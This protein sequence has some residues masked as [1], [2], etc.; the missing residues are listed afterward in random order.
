[1][2]IKQNDKRVVFIRKDKTL[3]NNKWKVVKEQSKTGF[4]YI[5]DTQGVSIMPYRFDKSGKMEVLIREEPNPLHQTILTVIAGKR[6]DHEEGNTW[7]QETAQRELGEESGYWVDDKHSFF[8]LGDVVVGKDYKEKDVFVAVD[9]TGVTP[10]KMKPDKGSLIEKNAKNHWVPVELLKR[11]LL[12]QAGNVD[13]YFMAMTSKFLAHMGLMKSEE[14]DLLK[15][16]AKIT[17]AKRVNVRPSGPSKLKGK[18]RPGHKYIRREPL[19]GGGYNYIYEEP[20]GR[21]KKA[22]EEPAKRL[23]DQLA[24]LFG[25]PQGQPE[26]KAPKKI[27]ILKEYSEIP[28]SLGSFTSE[29]SA[30]EWMG[31]IVD[32]ATKLSYSFTSSAAPVNSLY[33]FYVDSGRYL[34][35]GAAEIKVENKKLQPAAQAAVRNAIFNASRMLAAVHGIKMVLNSSKIE[36]LFDLVSQKLDDSDSKE[37]LATYEESQSFERIML[38]ALDGMKSMAFDINDISW[39]KGQDPKLDFVRDR[40][41]EAVD[42]LMRVRDHFIMSTFKFFIDK[43]DKKLDNLNDAFNIQAAIALIN[44][45]ETFTNSVTRRTYNRSDMRDFT[46]QLNMRQKGVYDGSA[47][48]LANAKKVVVDKIRRIVDAEGLASNFLRDKIVNS[49]SFSFLTLSS[50]GGSY[51]EDLAENTLAYIE[52]FGLDRYKQDFLFMSGLAKTAPIEGYVKYVPTAPDTPKHPLYDAAFEIMEKVFNGEDIYSDASVEDIY[53]RIFNRSYD[54]IGSLQASPMY[55][56]DIGGLGAV[57]NT[58]LLLNEKASPSSKSLAFIK[59]WSKFSGA[60]I[61]ANAIEEMV[62][63][64]NIDRGSYVNYHLA[65]NRSIVVKNEEMKKALGDSIEHAYNNTQ[66]EIKEVG[67]DLDQ[68]RLYRGNGKSELKS[69][70]S[71]WTS[72][73]TIAEKFGDHVVEALVPGKAVLIY[74]NN[75]NVDYWDFPHEKEFVVVPGLLPA[76]E[77]FEMKDRKLKSV[78]E[79]EE[80]L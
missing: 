16:K 23:L 53:A 61:I 52:L 27:D 9:L 26:E 56:F 38:N 69:T 70:A 39:L 71:S 28:E 34:K 25:R 79:K 15:D 45:F 19:P 74:Q 75:E 42:S 30:F 5:D 41:F 36:N 43:I 64:K 18:E 72:N 58:V 65:T 62:T 32:S 40:L 76:E 1:M 50:S 21:H 2:I 8:S 14:I 51:V 17:G 31:M 7:Y 57:M 10:G 67:G 44:N 37:N 3:F 46:N 49:P 20:K 48:Y 59:T 77:Q 35:V 6:D 47:K 63:R 22:E 80:L 33:N 68:F 4:V 24:Q 66:K 73:L 12:E 55:D 11:M 29:V 13:S 78:A 60:S 54:R